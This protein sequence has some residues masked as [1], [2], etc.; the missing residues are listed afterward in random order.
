MKLAS[1]DIFDTVLVRKCGKP[2]GIFTIMA[3][4][5]YPNDSIKRNEFIKWRRNVGNI[6]SR[7]IK[8]PNINDYYNFISPI[9]FVEYNK[10]QLV[11]IE[12]DIEYDNIAVNDEI[13]QIIEEKR[14]L[15]YTICFISDMYMDSLFL[16]KLLTKE[17]CIKTDE[18]IFVS[19]E[20]KARKSSGT[21]YDVVRNYFAPSEWIHYGDNYCSDIKKAKEKHIDSILVKTDF[22]E[23]EKNFTNN[24]KLSFLNGLQR[25]ARL[26]LGN[27]SFNT[28]AAD[29]VA[30][31]YIAYVDFILKEAKKLG[32]KRLYFLSR[33]AFI[34]QK[35]AAELEY[36]DIEIK[37]LFVSRK[38]LLMPY[39]IDP[40]P[41][42]FL[43]VQDHNSLIGKKVVE[44]LASLETSI[45]ELKTIYNIDFDFEKIESKQQSLYLLDKLMGKNSSYLPMLKK[46]ISDKRKLI[47]QYFEQQGL[48]DNIPK[49]MVDVGWL[50]T[51][52]LMINSILESEGC[53]KVHF[54]Y[55]GTRKDVLPNDCGSFISYFDSS[56]IITNL[57]AVIEN[58]YSASPFPST[59]GYTFTSNGVVPIYEN[60]DSYKDTFITKSNLN[61]CIWIANNLKKISF[62][63]D[64][65]LKQWCEKSL[66]E[67]LKLKFDIDL[68]PLQYAAEFER[69]PLVR[70]LTAFEILKIV[71]MASKVTAFD[72]GS[73]KISI[74]NKS[75]FLITSVM[76]DVTRKVK[77]TVYK[78]YSHI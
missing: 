62:I 46:R 42:K 57:T 67:M 52:R 66:K 65:L 70:K 28:L 58:Y 72:K 25:S 40:D 69:F 3:H 4:K 74:K 9:D 27:D 15:N 29:F 2:D 30:P 51:S 16:R 68:Q 77:E 41:N 8:E 71:V 49:A 43:A 1:F 11:D 75:L 45:S 13:K 21:L 39:L 35:I 7:F 6:A 10:S 78:L 22:T 60:N 19:C 50:G 63:D 56:G 24:D 47:V 44:V 38:S 76:S 33:D 37:E 54:F 20:C 53:P 61:V 5:L 73:L 34:L 55:F 36:S 12:K 18:K 32:I 48:L 17:D 59:I 14:K 23:I 31:A 64:D 26:C